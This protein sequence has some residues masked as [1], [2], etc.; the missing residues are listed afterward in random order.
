VSA[1]PFPAERLLLCAGGGIGAALLP[2]WI[3]WLREHFEVEVRVG[4]TRGA[5]ALV[6]PKALAV[7][8]GRPVFLD[9]EEQRGDPTVWHIEAAEWPDAV[10]VAPATA[11]LLAKLAHGIADDMVTTVLL[12]TERPVVLVPSLPPAME[13][14]RSTR[15]NLATLEGDGFGVAP[16][17]VGRVAASGSHG[18]GAML[19]APAAFACLKRFVEGQQRGEQAA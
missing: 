3:V 15:R 7:V 13:S 5:E 12:A 1:R 9:R 16:T 10:L 17:A 11:N 4:L 8:C 2:A 6:S 19:D 14:K 18:S